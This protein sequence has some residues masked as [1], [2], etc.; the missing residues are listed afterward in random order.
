MKFRG[1]GRAR[2]VWNNSSE[3]A[4]DVSERAE[5]GERPSS[6]RHI[7]MRLVSSGCV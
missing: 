2:Q 5:E 3:G 6:S 4:K 1:S 7:K